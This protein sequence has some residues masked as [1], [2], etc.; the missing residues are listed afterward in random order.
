M[1]HMKDSKV[2]FRRDRIALVLN[3]AHEG[4]EVEKFKYII[5]ICCVQKSSDLPVCYFLCWHLAY[6]V[7]ML[8][9]LLTAKDLLITG[10][11]V[12]QDTSFN[13]AKEFP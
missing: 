8:A 4:A 9:K 2:K 6:L 1:D 7:Q 11:Q 12:E 3:E 13:S 5:D 10:L